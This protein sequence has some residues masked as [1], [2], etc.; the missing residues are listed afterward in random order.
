MEQFLQQIL[1][2]LKSIN[3][4]LDVLTSSPNVSIAIEGEKFAR[5]VKG[6]MQKGVENALDVTTKATYCEDVHRSLSDIFTSNE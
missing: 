4:K 2:E 3:K 5:S 1:D 6:A